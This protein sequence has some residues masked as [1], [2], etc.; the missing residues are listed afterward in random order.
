MNRIATCLLAALAACGSPRAAEPPRN[1]APE[2]GLAISPTQSLGWLGLVP[3]PTGDSELPSYLPVHAQFPLVLSP[4]LSGRVEQRVSAIGTSGKLT[5]YKPAAKTQI[6]FGCDNNTLEVTPFIGKRLPPGVAWIL[7]YDA[8]S[9][10][11]PEAL[12]LRVEANAPERARFT[13]GPLVIELAR[14]AATTGTLA[15]ARGGRTLYTQPF[16][17][18]TMDG[19]PPEALAIDLT[20]RDMP[21]IPSPIGAWSIV[22]GGPILVALHTPGWEGSSLSALLVEDDRVRTADALTT[23]LYRCAF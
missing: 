15:L 5:T 8:P 7:P 11:Q 1:V 16:E 2:P 3:A 14:T 10:W 23:Y 21:G 17:R 19:A 6:T 9:T 4:P 18:S 20:E 22:P 12:A 13:A